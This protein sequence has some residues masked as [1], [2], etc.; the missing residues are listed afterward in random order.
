MLEQKIL[1]LPSKSTIAR[2]LKSSKS[3]AG[4]SEEFFVNFQNKLQKIEKILPG[5]SYGILAFDEMSVKTVVGIDVKNMKFNGLVDY[6]KT[7]P[8]QKDAE[9]TLQDRTADHALV[10]MFSSL[11]Y[12][13]HQPIA[14]FASKGTTKTKIL[15]KLILTAIIEL[16]NHGA[17]VLGLVCDGA[18]T[19]RSLWKAFGMRAEPARPVHCSTANLEHSLTEPYAPIVC[20][21][22][23]PAIENENGRKVFMISDVPHLIKCAKNGLWGSGKFEVRLNYLTVKK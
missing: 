18:Q 9:A 10:F 20:S 6:G 3:E 22:A 11:K 1:P 17:K 14:F 23:N 19:N 21:F 15:A 5:S 4:F 8:V 16:E 13:F 7:I 12:S 2:Y